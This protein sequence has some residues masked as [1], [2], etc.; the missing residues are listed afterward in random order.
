M[1]SINPRARRRMMVSRLV[2]SYPRAVSFVDPFLLS[3]AIASSS[4]IRLQ[5]DAAA[6]SQLRRMM[7][8]FLL[9]HQT[10]DTTGAFLRRRLN[11]HI[12]GVTVASGLLIRRR[13]ACAC[14]MEPGYTDS[15]AG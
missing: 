8:R 5:A 7:T 3:F 2:A 4:G 1:A 11:R 9:F 10:Q 15:L 13:P 12:A 14:R 6:G